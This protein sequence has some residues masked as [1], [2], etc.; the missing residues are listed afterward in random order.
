MVVYT[1]L[2]R[3]CKVSSVM[4]MHE[5]CEDMLLTIDILNLLDVILHK[6]GHWTSL[7]RGSKVDQN[8][9][10]KKHG[11]N[12]DWKHHQRL[13]NCSCNVYQNTGNPKHLQTMKALMKLE[14]IDWGCYWGI[15]EEAHQAFIATRHKSGSQYKHDE[16]LLLRQRNIQRG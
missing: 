6:N 10:N 14:S 11:C 3:G 15:V 13:D 8:K 4:H 1:S 16:I 7:W 5:V 12:V 2:W 9:G